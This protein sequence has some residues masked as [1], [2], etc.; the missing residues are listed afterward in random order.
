MSMK[1]SKAILL[2]MPGAIRFVWQKRS[3]MGTG[4]TMNT[5]QRIHLSNL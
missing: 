2:H 4:C 5:L 3:F 1:K